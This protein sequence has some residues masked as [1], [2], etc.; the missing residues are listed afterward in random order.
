MPR[1][2]SPASLRLAAVGVTHERI[3]AR[4]GVDRST[5]TAQLTGQHP[6]RPYLIPSIRSV[7]GSE[8]ADDVAEILGIEPETADA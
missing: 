3:A 4:A 2:Y 7:A 6:A 1:R 5:I 8:V